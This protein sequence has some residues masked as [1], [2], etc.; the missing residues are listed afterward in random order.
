[1]LSWITSQSKA[2]LI[3]HPNPDLTPNQ[4]IQLD[5]AL[6]KIDQG[7]PLP[8]VIGCWEFFGLEFNVSPDVLIPRPE[9]EWLV[10]EGIAWLGDHLQRRTCMDLGT[11]SGCLAV[12]LAKNIPDLKIIATDIS[13][14]ALL[15]ASHNSRNH[16]VNNQISF[17]T[18][19]LLDGFSVNVDLLIANLPYIPSDKLVKLPVFQSE[20]SHALDGGPDGLSY[21]QRLMQKGSGFLAPG[22][23]LLIELDET[24]GEKGL[25]LASRFFPGADIKLVQ[26]LAGQDRY[27]KIQT[28]Q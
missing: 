1:L 12:S 10:E 26:D 11:G 22:G 5:D 2:A 24:N 9:S 16:G 20:P 27:L 28:Y 18:A 4:Q 23:L 21:I 19:D 7:M 25:D 15:I 17:L 14:N 3:A 8:Y 13:F 6:Q